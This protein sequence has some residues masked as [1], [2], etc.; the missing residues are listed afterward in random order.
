MFDFTPSDG[1]VLHDRR[2]HELDEE[3]PVELISD[4]V[5]ETLYEYALVR[6]SWG[7]TNIDSGPIAL[8][9]VEELYDQYE[10]GITPKGEIA[11]S[12][13]EVLNYFDLTDRYLNAHPL[14]FDVEFIRDLHRDYF[15]RVPLE[16]KA[17]PGQFK[18]QPNVI[19]SPFGTVKTTPP[20]EVKA[21]LQA[22]TDWLNDE[23]WDLPVLT[24]AALF[25]HEF[26]CIHPFGDGNGRI[27]RLLTLQILASRGLE[28][29]RYCPIDDA[30]NQER[31]E[32]YRA[33]SAADQGKLGAWV[34]YFGQAVVEGYRRSRRLA[35][36]LQLIPTSIPEDAQELLEW[37]YIHEIESFRPRDIER[38]FRQKSRQTVT[39][40][41]QQLQDEGLIRGEGQ[42][43]GR[44]YHVLW[45]AEVRELRE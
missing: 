37:C 11:P 32:Y 27:G 33:L 16:N 9:R 44:E 41:L 38:F 30:I 2:A 24:R 17:K 14:H 21:D 6:N 15:R 1:H 29:V 22:L 3:L 13:T 26:Q 39:R 36:R 18:Q 12:D 10:A 34:S 43:A 25:F 20:E 31:Q 4:R 23:A 40:R 45:P 7:T 28:N 42:G 5:R 35:H 19:T 8:K